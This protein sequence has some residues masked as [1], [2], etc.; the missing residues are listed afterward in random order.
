MSFVFPFPR[1][2]AALNLETQIENTDKIV[3]TFEAKLAQDSV[4]PASPNALQDRA[5]DLQVGEQQLLMKGGRSLSWGAM[6]EELD[7]FEHLE[8]P[9]M[10]LF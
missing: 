9:V 1:A 3:S 7:L 4:I 6:W 5:N 10:K 2:K 8:A